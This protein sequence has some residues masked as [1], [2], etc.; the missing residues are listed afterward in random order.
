MTMSMT[1]LGRSQLIENAF[2]DVIANTKRHDHISYT[3]QSQH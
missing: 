1:E 2:G 3:L